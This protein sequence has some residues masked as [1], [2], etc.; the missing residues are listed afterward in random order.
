MVKRNIISEIQEKNQRASDA[1]L[2][3]HVELFSL[4]HTF[5]NLDKSQGALLALL[6]MGIASCIEV[7]ARAAIKRLI[8]FGN[9]Y[10]ERAESFKDNI[11]FDF[12]LTKALS[13]RE[14]TF[15]DLISH[16]LPVSRVDHISSHF[17]ALFKG[18]RLN[19]KDALSQVRVFIEPDEDELFGNGKRGATQSK[20]PFLISDVD[21]VMKDI[22]LIFEIRHLV[23]HEA[24]FKAVSFDELS[25]F[26]ISARLF[27][28]ALFEMVEQTLNPG[29]SRNGYGQSIQYLYKASDIWNSANAVQNR[30]WEQV[31]VA[32][33]EF[34]GLK[35]LFEKTVKTFAEY[36]EAEQAFR[37]ASHEMLTGNGM[38]DMESHVSMQLWQHRLDYLK[39]VEEDTKFFLHIN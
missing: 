7:T 15:G 29:A 4:E 28:D 27:V 1:Y 11:K 37:L 20:A 38:R 17:E 24:N 5:T 8:D 2:S 21:A 22:G 16:S 6:L 34:K 32:G 9:P 33:S 25:G 23:A 13:L 36:H 26:F 19:F 10:L 14:I 3:G 18:D 31:N 35:E 30:I 12:A 39:I